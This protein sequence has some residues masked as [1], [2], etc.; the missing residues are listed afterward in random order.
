MS[1]LLA[2]KPRSLTFERTA[3][4]ALTS[5]TAWEGLFERLRIETL[6]NVKG[7]S[8]LKR[9]TQRK[10]ILI[11]AGAGGVG[12]IAIQLAKRI[13]GLEVIASAS[14]TSSAAWCKSLGAD[15]VG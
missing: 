4:L 5:I 10:R 8:P 13:A 2:H 1:A 7:H 15:H 6:H 9:R 12:S 14:K 11:I 3:G